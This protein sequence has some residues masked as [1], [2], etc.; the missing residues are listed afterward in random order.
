[1]F[2]SI[3]LH[4][5]I[6]IQEGKRLRKYWNIVKNRLVNGL[7]INLECV[8]ITFNHGF[9]VF[10]VGSGPRS[11]LMPSSSRQ[12]SISTSGRNQR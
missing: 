6:A 1:M 5:F 9:S 10:N 2:I 11:I 3:A 8:I 7:E 4:A 12:A